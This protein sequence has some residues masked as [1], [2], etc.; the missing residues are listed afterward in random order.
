MAVFKCKMCGGALEVA[1]SLSTTTCDYCGSQQTLP[2]INDDKLER[3]YERAN[4][5]RRNNEFDKAMGIYEQILDENNEDAESYWSI[6]LCR[7]GIEYVED[8]ASH[9]R[10]PTVNRA[11][12]TSIFDDD[13]YKSALKYADIAQRCIYEQEA[14]TIN[15]IQ[16]GI[17]DIS[18]REEPFDVFICYKETDAHGQR[19]HDSVYANELYHELTREGFKVFFARITLEDKLGV[20]YE[21]YIFAA[22]NSAKVMVVIGTRPEY[23]NAVWVKNEWSRFLTMIRN[24]ERKILIPAYRDMDAYDLP[25]EFSHLQSQ[26]MNKLG[27][28]PDLVR[29]IKKFVEP[30]A[31]MN[32]PPVSG[33]NTGN[34]TDEPL[35]LGGRGTEPLL[36]RAALFLEAGEWDNA[37]AYCEKVL[38]MDPENATAYIYKLLAE[39]HGVQESDL[40]NSERLL[41]GMISYKNAVRFADEATAQ[42][43]IGYN[44]TIKEKLEERARI[45]Q[46]QERIEQERRM[47]AEQKRREQERIEQERRMLAEKKRQEENALQTA[48]NNAASLLSKQLQEKERIEKQIGRKQVELQTSS[49][50]KAKK[51]AFL[52]L[53]SG[54]VSVASLIGL[55]IASNEYEE[56]LAGLFGVLFCVTGLCFLIFSGMQLKAEGKSRWLLLINYVTYGIFS[57]VMAFIGIFRSDK[58]KKKQCLYE[59]QQLNAELRKVDEQIALTRESLREIN[60][61]IDA[62]R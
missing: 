2:R 33:L 38:D 14:E 39:L 10:I 58:A 30:A 12:Y 27:F 28:M 1:D 9:K 56:V 34:I 47:L 31:Q 7:Y 42:R 62:R 48:K 24:G 3:L 17:L 51:F 26:D 40:A 29:G 52:T 46:E 53:L 16:K 44:R 23:F 61:K 5:F 36:K 6:V 55:G 21:P 49:V 50:K 22:L 43:L 41:E 11:Q 8:P 13:N 19:T 18:Q 37:D 4:H 60:Q 35:P 54:V 57:V 59:L 15:E 45:R 32:V 20:A 25:K